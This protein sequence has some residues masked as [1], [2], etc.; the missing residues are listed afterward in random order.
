LPSGWD[1]PVLAVTL[2]ALSAPAILSVAPVV[3]SLTALQPNLTAVAYLRSQAYDPPA[4]A[5]EIT[6]GLGTAV[7]S[8]FGPCPICMGSLVTPLTAGPEA[9]E[10]PVRPWAAYADAASLL[11][12]AI[13]TAEAADLP[14][15]MPLPLLLAVAGLALLGVLGQA[16]GEV[17]SGRLRL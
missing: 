6:T 3:V 11:L 13:A 1:W 14:R 12:I 7:A 10:R 8:L 16:L 4:R 9:G 15:A 2:P 5:I 17:T